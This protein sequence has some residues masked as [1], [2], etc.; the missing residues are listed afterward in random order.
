[1][2]Q[3]KAHIVRRDAHVVQEKAHIVR[4]D[5]HIVQEKA[6]IVRRDT[7]PFFKK[8]R[9]AQ[10]AG[11]SRQISRSS[12][13]RHRAKQL[14]LSLPDNWGEGGRHGGGRE[15]Q[16]RRQ[17]MLDI[18]NPKWPQEVALRTARA[19]IAL[20][21]RYRELDGRLNGAA[22]ALVA[23]AD[24]MRD[25]ISATQSA[26]ADR[27]SATTEQLQAARKGAQQ[28]RAFRRA[29]RLAGLD[30]AVLR[31]FGVGD[32][33]DGRKVGSVAAALQVVLDAA[34]EQPEAVSKAGIVKED[35]E[36]LRA[37]LVALLS[38]DTSQ[39]TKKVGAKGAR[40]RRDAVQLRLEAGIGMVLA[41]AAVVFRDQPA[42]AA[43][44]EAVVPGR[45][46]ARASQPP[47][48]AEPAAATT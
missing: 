16:E 14:L 33:V 36:G 15:K 12:E 37:T 43:E 47:A 34:A 28:V 3:E 10:A 27:K 23:N 30:R 20:S 1:V 7:H 25:A 5:A 29:V 45:G 31:R 11:N 13:I 9:M 18:K 35:L 21:R 17:R 26:R 4:R 46:N 41:T 39:E 2:V 42:I 40:A 6:H 38:A 48:P 32:R 44:F 22:D 8:K 24:E 19:V